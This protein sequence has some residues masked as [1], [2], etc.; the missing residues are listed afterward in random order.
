[1]DLE[2][3]CAE[4]VDE[5]NQIDTKNK[6]LLKQIQDPNVPAQKERASGCCV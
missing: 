6:E 1:M 5:I 2:K 3:R 4:L